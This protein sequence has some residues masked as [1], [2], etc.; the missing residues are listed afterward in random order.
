M[1]DFTV[2]A[3]DRML[4]K[5]SV[6]GFGGS[7]SIGIRDS[8]PL[9]ERVSDDRSWEQTTTWMMSPKNTIVYVHPVIDIGVT[10]SFV[11]LFS[12][13]GQGSITIK[14]RHRTPLTDW[15]DW[16]T[17]T[18][19]AIQARYLQVKAEVYGPLPI[20][21]G[22]SV[23][24]TAQAKEEEVNDIVMAALE[25][26]YRIGTGDI[27]IPVVG[28]YLVYTVIQLALQNVGPGW[29]WEIVDKTSED[30][31]LY[32]PRVKIYNGSGDPADCTLDAY[33][34]GL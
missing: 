21:A 34:K 11:P 28:A 32:G 30:A 10:T 27:R 5:S 24:L 12:A 1:T 13:T 22:L 9:D 14:Y 15:T 33:I 16:L 26:P 31:T 6:G 25:S 23:N 7:M 19:E 20:L 3:T 8:L 29:T 17:S 2:T 4:M 18:G